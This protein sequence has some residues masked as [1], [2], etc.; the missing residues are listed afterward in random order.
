[1]GFH[2]TQT[3]N[4]INIHSLKSFLR[5]QLTGNQLNILEVSKIL[6]SSILVLLSSDPVWFIQVI[7]MIMDDNAHVNKNG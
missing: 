7:S 1:M 6:N 3:L 5:G 4:Y 2:C